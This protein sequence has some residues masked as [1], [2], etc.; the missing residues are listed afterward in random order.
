M[1]VTSFPDETLL[2]VEEVLFCSE[3][4]G[5]PVVADH[6]RVCGTVFTAVVFVSADVAGRSPPTLNTILPP[7]LKSE[8]SSFEHALSSRAAIAIAR[9]RCFENVFLCIM[10]CFK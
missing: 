3:L 2:L 8:L 10:L 6:C 7:L 1:S 4:P 5:V 9:G